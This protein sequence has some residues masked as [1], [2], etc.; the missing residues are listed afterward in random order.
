MSSEGERH[1]RRLFLGLQGP[2]QVARFM[3]AFLLAQT[4]AE[5]AIAQAMAA[6]VPLLLL[7]NV[8]EAAAIVY[9]FQHVYRLWRED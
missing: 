7:I 6:N 1:R 2:R 4:V 9:Y 8:L 3:L 5:Y